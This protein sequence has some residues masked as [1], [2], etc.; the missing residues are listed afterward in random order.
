MLLFVLA[1]AEGSCQ[2][3]ITW[4]IPPQYDRVSDFREGTAVVVR[5]DS[6]EFIDG[7]GMRL[8]S[9]QRDRVYVSSGPLVPYHDGDYKYGYLNRRGKI[10]I[11]PRFESA[12]PFQEELAIVTEQRK[13]G[14]IDGTGAFAIK[15]SFALLQYCSEDLLGAQDHTSMRWGFVNK[16]G[17]QVIPFIY[18]KTGLG[19]YT[20]VFGVLPFSEGL[21][22]AYLDGKAGYIDKKGNVIIPHQYEEGRSFENGVAHVRLNGVL[23][24]IDKAGNTIPSPVPASETTRHPDFP[25]LEEV[26]RVSEG[27]MGAKQNGMWGFVRVE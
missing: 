3:K 12:H 26:C 21:A 11:R 22:V 23:I 24:S 15:P 1:S 20:N 10:F 13:Y 2:K 9:Y 4:A 16:K 8:T 27:L 19:E 7:T 17:L 14:A 18:D 25:G 6:V 5:G